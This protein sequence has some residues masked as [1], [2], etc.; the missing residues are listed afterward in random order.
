MA[1]SI[2]DSND[3]PVRSNH[4]HRYAVPKHKVRYENEPA[5]PRPGGR[6]PAPPDEA[7]TTAETWVGWVW[8]K[9]SGWSR[10]CQA[11]TLPEAT[12]MLA[13]LEGVASKFTCLTGGGIP[14]H[15]PIP[16]PCDRTARRGRRG[17][18]QAPGPSSPERRR[19]V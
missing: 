18:G 19:H 10:A 9:R 13:A 17:R 1:E 3:P 2:F 16:R 7:A 14:S 15:A 12:R 6:P 11:S 8:H 5:I 4:K